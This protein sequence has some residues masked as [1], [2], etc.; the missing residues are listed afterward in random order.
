MSRRGLFKGFVALAGGAAIGEGLSIADNFSRHFSE[1]SSSLEFLFERGTKG[2]SYMPSTPANILP[3][4]I[5]EALYYAIP[6]CQD[7]TEPQ[8]R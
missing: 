5:S 6:H 3:R 7:S 8:M 1:D 2:T 4:E